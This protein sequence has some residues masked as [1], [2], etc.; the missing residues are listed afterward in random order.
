MFQSASKKPRGLLSRLARDNSGVSAIEFGLVTPM[1]AGSLLGLVELGTVVFERT[2]MH[3]AVRAG[4]QYIMD[5]GNNLTQARAVVLSSWT[6]KPIDAEVVVTKFCLCDE[7][8]HVCNEPC[9]D[10][11][12]PEAYTRLEATAVL[13]GVVYS[14]GTS[15]DDTVRIR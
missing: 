13:G 10:M 2:D 5:G 7:V 14:Y 3:G 4:A 9:S 11:S 8:V 1:I 15:A 6:T 12:V